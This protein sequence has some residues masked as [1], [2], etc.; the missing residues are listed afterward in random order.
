MAKGY[1]GGNCCGEK[2]NE[3]VID[4]IYYENGIETKEINENIQ[5]KIK[6]IKLTINDEADENDNK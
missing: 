3:I 5:Q 1:S 4:V 6:E 2:K